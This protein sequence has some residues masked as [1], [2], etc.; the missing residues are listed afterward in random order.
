MHVVVVGGGIVGLASAYYLRR[1]GIE[2]TV[3]ERDRIGAGSTPRAGGGIRAQFSTPVS[4]RLSTES[5]P[6][7]ASF[8][9]EFGVDIDYHRSGYLYLARTEGTAERIRE[10]TEIHAD[11]GVPS[12]FVSPETAR[13]H[14]PELDA[15]RYV[16]A[17]YCPTDGF[18]DPERALQ[19]F[20]LAAAREG[21]AFRVG[22][23][24][25][26]IEQDD[27]GHVAG[28]RTDD[29]RLDADFVVNAA[30]GWAPQVAAMAG[31][32]LPI[33]AERRQLLVVDPGTEVP[34]SVPFVTDL[35]SGAYFR[36]DR[37]GLAK[38]GGHFPETDPADHEA[39]GPADPEASAADPDAFDRGYDEAWAER[40]L[41]EAAE[42]AGYFGEGTTV[43]D[44][45]AGL[46]AMTPDH[47]PIIEEHEGLVTAAG[48]SGHGFMQAP[49]TGQVVAE[50][51]A[52]GQASTV[53]VSGLDA[54]RFDRGEAL[55][56]TF[57]SA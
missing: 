22:T 55:A 50:L 28:V 9:E 15:D 36:P 8:D 3:V 7:W 10:T 57:Y 19:G 4:I 40:A 12:E 38:V 34:L 37:G 35:D 48:F 6:V 14:C 16:G 46:Y 31:R 49:A 53:D 52:D 51:V 33:R 32:D 5:I 23:R 17:T 2:V 39:A 29:G 42:V 41:A 18:A 20:A 13:E 11:H 43:R 26:G 56:E 54:D 25:T 44:G 30:G 21:A 45:W 27:D 24:V 47:H 1:R